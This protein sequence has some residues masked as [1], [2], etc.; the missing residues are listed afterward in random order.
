MSIEKFIDDQISKAIEAG[1]F[2]DLPGKG[3]PLDLRAYFETPEDLRM[4]YSILKSNNFVPEE[5]ELL[6]EINALRKSLEA[7]SDEDQKQ[8]LNK[9]ITEKTYI[10]NMLIEKRKRR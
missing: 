9:E 6:R 10:F 8:S 7:S 1:E 3:K 2:D 4:A 5:V